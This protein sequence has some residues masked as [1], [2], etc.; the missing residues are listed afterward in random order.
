[1]ASVYKRIRYVDSSGNQVPKATPG[2]RKIRA[3]VWSIRHK[4]NHYKGYTDKEATLAKAAALVKAEARGEMDMLDL[5]ESH[6]NRPLAEHVGD[7]I[8][9]LI[10]LKRSESYVRQ[11]GSCMKRLLAEC[12]WGKLA[13][14]N[15]ADL[16]AW[17]PKAMATV[18]KSKTP[19][20]IPMSPST[21]NHYSDTARA[22]CLWAIER[23]RMARNPL[24][25]VNPVE[26]AGQLRRQRRALVDEE[27]T[28]FLSVVGKRHRLAYQ[29]LLTT[30]L[31][32][33]EL[34]QLQWGDIK[35][36]A[37]LPFI[38][39]RAETTKAG[40]ADPLPV[41]ADIAALL[42]DA[43]GTDGDTDR[44]CHV[45]TMETHRRYLAKAGIPYEDGAGRR[46]DLHAM[47]HSYGTMLARAGI[48]PRVAMSLMRHTDMKLTMNV[49]TDP[50]VFNM[51]GAVEKL[52]SVVTTAAA[53]VATATDGIIAINRQCGPKV[54]TTI[55]PNRPGRSQIESTDEKA[56][57]AKSPGFTGQIH[58]SAPTFNEGFER[59]GDRG[60][61]DDIHVGNVT[62]Y[63]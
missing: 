1:M 31:R 38:E 5:Y 60:R 30:G 63:H 61:T 33:D 8:A 45:P 47:R 57:R 12:K 22:F 21:Q 28:S 55:V 46:I 42:R 16:I 54:A 14:I 15:V 35:L 48:A 41:R 43:R 34:K 6:R 13:D 50:R 39:L 53:S 56:R 19:K 27:L 24:D 29:L 52:P 62:L 20:I 26:T 23:K 58:A 59:A 37:P 18:G 44:V 2:A 4:G 40:R 9:E 51:A 49:Y 17:R 7:W 32:R 3:D 25:G 11:S 36:N 10:Q